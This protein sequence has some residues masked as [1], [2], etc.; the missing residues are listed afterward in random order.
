[1]IGENGQG[2][3]NL[4]EA[5]HFFEFG[6]SFRTHRDTELIQFGADFARAEVHCEFKNGDK[7]TFAASIQPDGTK[8]IKINGT[9]VER[10][11]DLVGRYPSVLFGPHDLAVVSG[12]P[13]ERRRFVDMIGSMTDPAYIR[14]AKEYRR[15]LQQRNAALKARSS[16]YEMNIWNEQIIRAGADFLLKRRDLVAAIETV[17]VEHGRELGAPYRFAVSY[18]SALLREAD[19]MAAGAE[20]GDAA[21]SVADVYAVK[22][23][24]LEQEE[25]R[26]CTTRAGPHRDD[27]R[28]D[29]DEHDLRK[30]GSQGQR[31]LFAVLLKLAELT[32]VERELREPCILLLDDVF[33]EFDHDIM[34]KLQGLLDGE[35]QVFVTSPVE[36]PW[37]ESTN[38]RT[39][40]VHDGEVT[41]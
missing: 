16:D 34:H 9:E 20:D 15:V 11:S 12:P 26:R 31:R 1:M 24:A 4:L 19:A 17:L 18:E 33:S 10:L 30:Y 6:R 40:R 32:H 23:G 3:T 7:E 39:L 36:V 5:I 2:K 14:V 28:L 35:R 22:L 38:A 37:A 41:A 8:T 25:R 29:L 27:V 13:A 21:P